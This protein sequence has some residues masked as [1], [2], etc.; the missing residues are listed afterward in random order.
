MRINEKD[1]QI[2]KSDKIN[3]D[4]YLKYFFHGT[5][6]KETRNRKMRKSILRDLQYIY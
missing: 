4:E 6:M 5:P 3:F 1:Q 2:E